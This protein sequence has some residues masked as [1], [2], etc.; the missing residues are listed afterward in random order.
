VLAHLPGHG[1][2]I[3]TKESD[4]HAVYACYLC[5]NYIDGR[6]RAGPQVLGD[7]IVLDAMLRGLSETQAR[8]VEAGLITVKGYDR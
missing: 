3:G 2:G 4:L 1:K 5:H 8:M 7:A 6:R